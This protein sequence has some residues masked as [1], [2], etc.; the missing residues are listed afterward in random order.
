VTVEGYTPQTVSGTLA[1]GI[2]VLAKTS[3]SPRLDAQILL[4]FTLGRE[5]E[6][7]ISHGEAFLSRAQHEKFLS[8]CEK[9]ATGMPVA[10]ITGF[11]G[12]F[13]RE[14]A[15]NEHVLI[16][17]AE[18][19]H[20]VDEAIAHLRS[21]IDPRAPAQQLFTI[22]E[23]GVGS[24]AIACTIAAE[25]PTAVIEGTDASNAAL[26]VAQYNAR[27]LNVHGRCKFHYADVVRATDGKSY[28][29]VIANLPYIPS[30]RLPQK[31]DP[32]G[33]EPVMALDGGPD[34]LTHYRKL[35]E[36]APRMLRA[37]GLALMEA[38]PPTIEPLA[39]L[40]LRAFPGAD[41]TVGHDYAGLQRYVAVKR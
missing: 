3:P 30:N 8:L 17:R 9:R 33:F 34:G 32:V 27:R 2:L 16:P 14:F 19:E 38:A 15:V 22:F 31:P 10:Y 40:A 36:S 37:G 24:G 1:R 21:R 11:A 12:F 7:L 25:L 5:K 6:W 18:T 13:G 26:K 41:V 35:L 23:A 4:S 28:D 20:M 39:A 29:V